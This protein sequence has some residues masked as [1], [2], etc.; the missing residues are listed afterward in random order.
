MIKQI[1]LISILML[2]C[3]D[4]PKRTPAELTHV[5]GAEEEYNKIIG[6]INYSK[7]DGSVEVLINFPEN[8]KKIEADGYTVNYRWNCGTYLVK[9]N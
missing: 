8:I 1:L 7:D 5:L 3:S 2:G 6:R 9:W 4:P